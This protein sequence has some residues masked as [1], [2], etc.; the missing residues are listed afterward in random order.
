MAQQ[1]DIVANLLMKVDGAEAG[2]NKLKSS[3]S[4]LKL[5]DGLDKN[6]TKSFANLDG[7]FE[8]Y[9]NQLNK[10][11]KTKGDVSAFAKTGKELEAELD[12]VSKHMTELTGKKIDFKV[13]SEPIKQLQKDLTNLIEQQQKLSN[14]ALNFKIEGSNGQSIQSLLEGI[15]KTAGDTKAGRAANSA[16]ANLQMGDVA[17]TKAN[18]ETI[19]ASLGRLKQAKQD[20]EVVAGSGLN[21]AGA[22][23]AIKAQLDT[24]TS[25]LQK[26]KTDADAAKASLEQMQGKQ[27]GEAANQANKLAKDMQQVGASMNQ[28][29]KSAQD[30]ASSSFRMANQLD[31]LKSSTQYFFGLRNMINLL[32]RG[33]REALDTVKELDAG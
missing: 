16:I 27:L 33:F 25:G 22:A 17:S 4:K 10:G 23:N 9:R 8:R 6:L 24:A 2:I 28:A 30:F 18:I 26:V 3:L 20:A 13:N 31:Q 12:R 29:N 1:I 32:K 21:M 15:R 11:F 14:Q 5:P 19:I 7:I